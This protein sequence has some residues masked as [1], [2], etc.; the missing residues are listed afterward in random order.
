MIGLWPVFLL[1]A[2]VLIPLV[3]VYIWFH[4]MKFGSLR[5]YLS[6]AAGVISVLIAGLAQGF[7]PLH[8]SGTSPLTGLLFGVFIRVSLIEELSRAFVLFLLFYFFPYSRIMFREKPGSKLLSGSVSFFG[9]PSGLA[10]GLGFAAGESIFYGIADPGIALM[11]FSA[12]ALHGAC[13]IRVGTALGY[14]AKS[15]FYSVFIFLTAVLIHGIFNF[16]ILNPGIPEFLPAFIAFA[17]LAS[18]LISVY[19]EN[20]N[21][22]LY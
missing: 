20:R 7:M 5:F 15:R 4:K 3:P 18:S 17:A 19:F 21:A 13:G 22:Y 1:L 9:A 12:A 10:A 11:R 6:V 16:C 14:L 2:I 8:L